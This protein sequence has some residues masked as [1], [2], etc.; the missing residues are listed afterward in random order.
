MYRLSTKRSV[1][2]GLSLFIPVIL[3]LCF[4]IYP[5]LDLLR[6][7]FYRWDG[8]SVEQTFIGLDNYVRLFKESPDLWLSLRNN[9]IYFVIH[10]LFIPL[11]L[12][13][14]VM[15]TKK[16]RGSNIF[17]SLTFMPYIVNGVAIAYAFSY[18][19]SPINGAFNNI[20]TLLGLEN[21]I[22]N[23][24]SDPAIV[25]LTLA[26]V[27]VWRYSGYHVVLFFAALQSIPNDILEAATIDGAG[28][29]QQF[30]RIQLPSI[31]LV[32]DFTLF[33]NVRGA[34]QMF[35]IPFVMTSG[36]PGYASSTFTLFTLDT[37]FKFDSFGMASTMAIAIIVL[38]VLVTLVQNKVVAVA[39]RKG[40]F[41]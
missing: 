8:V 12:M 9:L 10:T 36:G 22:R 20:L 40:G 13:F 19:Y 35:D 21:W 14:A 6:M 37:A 1:F 26:S 25:N 28:A 29:W 31:S 34:L 39:R 30:W 27:S 32:I 33:Q 5:A 15:L 2:I 24:L 4:V 11:E 16:L 3:L 38:I 41:S 23:W 18:F 17:K 7:S